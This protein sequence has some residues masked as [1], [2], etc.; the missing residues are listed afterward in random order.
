M[1]NTDLIDDYLIDRNDGMK[2]LLTWFLNQVMQQ[3]ALNQIKAHPYE[4]TGHR[5]ARRN[6]IRKRSL[7]TIHG[8]VMLDKP[9]FREVP[10]KTSMIL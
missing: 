10:F 2:K 8:E 7:K 4:R 3:E 5:I 1:N 6:G 9:Q